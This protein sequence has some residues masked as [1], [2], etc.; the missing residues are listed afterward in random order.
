MTPVRKLQS[1]KRRGPRLSHAVVEVVFVPETVT[2]IAAFGKLV[3][4]P[5]RLLYG[6]ITEELLPRWGLL[7]LLVCAAW[8]LLK[9]RRNVPIVLHAV[10]KA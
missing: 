5:T 7:T 3:P 2:R 4:L 9:A 6:G 1:N 10:L 8:R